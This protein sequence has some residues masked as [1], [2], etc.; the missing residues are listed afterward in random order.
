MK[1][2]IVEKNFGMCKNES[3]I[4]TVKGSAAELSMLSGVAKK[5]FSAQATSAQSERDF[6]QVG[7]VRTTCR[8]WMFAKKLS[9][10]EFLNF[11]V[12]MDFF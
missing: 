12:K 5:I 8:V 7:L 10:V 3:K 9:D 4:Y 1:L 6:S 2:T 11:V